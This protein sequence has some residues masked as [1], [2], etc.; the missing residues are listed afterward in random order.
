MLA[1]G[2]AEGLARLRV[3]G[4]ELERAFRDTRVGADVVTKNLL[5]MLDATYDLYEHDARPPS[6]VAERGPSRQA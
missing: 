2:L 1:D 6:Q 5:D 3:T 4:R